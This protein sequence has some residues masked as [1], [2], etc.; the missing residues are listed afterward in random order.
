[1]RNAIAITLTAFVISGCSFLNSLN[2]MYFNMARFDNNEYMLAVDVRTQA[3][4]G[5][6]KCGTPEVNR[7]VSI[8]WAKSL[9]LKNYSES[10]PNNEETVTMTSE[11]LEIV[12]GLDKRY[13]IDKKKTSMAYCTN[14]FGNIEKN[15]TLITNVVGNKPH[16]Q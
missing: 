5:A 13:N 4:L 15:A 8:L 14:K 7:E 16:K 10:I 9:I 6:R 2:P 3:N 11:L 1:M 12:R